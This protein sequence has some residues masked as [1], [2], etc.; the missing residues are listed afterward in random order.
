MPL[1]MN[2]RNENSAASF[3]A[4]ASS[5]EAH[6]FVQTHAAEWLSQWVPTGQNGT[7]CL[8]FGAGT[9]LLTRHLVDQ[10]EH[11]ECSDIEPEMVRLCKENH[12]TATH[13]VRDAWTAHDSDAGQW[14]LVTASSVLQWAKEPG[15]VMGN[16]RKLLKAE[17]RIIAGFFIQPS[18]PEMFAVTGGENPLIWRDADSWKTV[19]EFAG[20]DI[21]RMESDER[22]YH[23]PSALD[24]W[25][26]IHSTGTAVSRKISPSQMMRFFRD[27]ELQFRDAKGVYATWTFCRVELKASS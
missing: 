11:L 20:L 10:F 8:E 12:P 2:R 1:T 4:K 7:R 5:Y 15:R 18:L 3:G 27:Y 26:S 13:S 17:G 21:V 23:Y 24:F 25:K 6:A 16:W 14:D 9:G 19:F 22:R